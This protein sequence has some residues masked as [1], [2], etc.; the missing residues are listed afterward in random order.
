MI[1]LDGGKVEW[2]ISTVIA[3][4]N[5]LGKDYAVVHIN[6][7]LFLCVCV[8]NQLY[9]LHT[10]ASTGNVMLLCGQWFYRI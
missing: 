3:V 7:L 6:F 10:I 1:F 5:T 4:N 2:P 9:Q 8:S